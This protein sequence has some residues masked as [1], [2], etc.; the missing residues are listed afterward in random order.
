MKVFVVEDSVAVRERL[1]EMI[2]GIKDAIVVGI[3]QDGCS[4]IE[5][6]LDTR[7]DVAILDIE[8]RRGTGIEV[9]AAV[10]SRLPGLTAIMLSNY[11]MPQYR[12][13]SVNAGAD[14]FFDKV[15]D[16]EK[17][18]AVLHGLRDGHC[19]GVLH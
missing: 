13:A 19:G 14:Y 16:L 3:A 8:L 2:A 1:V 7:P 9:L 12:R 11:S 6:I 18:M 15:Q 17:L 5:G 10:R 4:A